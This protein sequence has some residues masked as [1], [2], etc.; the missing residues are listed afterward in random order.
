[1]PDQ[2]ATGRNQP[3]QGIRP[4]HVFR[5]ASRLSLVSL[6]GV[7]LTI[8]TTFLIAMQLGSEDYGAI[9]FVL[10][11]YSFATLTRLGIF[12]AGV[13][14]FIYHTSREDQRA[15]T[16]AQNVGIT[17]DTAFALL[18]GLV[19]LAATPFLEDPLRQLGFMLAPVATLIASLSAFLIQLHVA[20][21]RFAIVARVNLFRVVLLPGLQLG[22]VFVFGPAAVFVAPIVVDIATVLL[23]S[24]VRAG[25]D[26][27]PTWSWSAARPLLRTGLPFGLEVLVYWAYRLVGSTSVAAF[28]DLAVLGIYAFALIPVTVAVRAIAPVQSVLTPMLWREMSIDTS[29]SR[30]WAVDAARVTRTVAVLAGVLIGVA[31]AAF[32]PV[33]EL[34]LPSFTET[35]PIFEVLSITILLLVVGLLPSLVLNS[36]VVNKQALHLVIWLVGLI[37]NAAANVIVLASGWGVMAVAWNDVW[38]QFALVIVLYEVASPYFLPRRGRRR[39]Y[40]QL[41]GVLTTT[42]CVGLVL[43]A[44]PRPPVRSWSMALAQISLRLALVLSVW[45]ALVGGVAWLRRRP[46]GHSPS[47]SDDET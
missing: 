28:E 45:T 38:I 3:T 41:L 18:P 8:P 6:L 4:G 30:R 10:L 34:A 25:L 7:V 5:S 9:Q 43:R 24:V 27:R 16:L 12:E 37:V 26:V 22:G 47:M 44:I 40:L 31:Q 11:A 35:I 23:L 20:R 36:P 13:R 1:M 17:Y 33:V 14:A 2:L 29:G 21:M 42:V 32:G 39:M 19:L 15:A 46:T